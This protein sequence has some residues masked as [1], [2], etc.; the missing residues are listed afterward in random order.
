MHNFFL[1]K[2]DFGALKKKN[3]HKMKN[4]IFPYNTT[5]YARVYFPLLL[6]V[7]HF[8]TLNLTWLLQKDV[9]FSESYTVFHGKSILE[10]KWIC[11]LLTFTFLKKCAS[12]RP[13][14][15]CDLLISAHELQLSSTPWKEVLLMPYCYVTS[16]ITSTKLHINRGNKVNRS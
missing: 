3:E 13:V 2:W 9:S 8:F 16:S 4:G 11:F 7:L 6:C 10:E 5:R 12:Y 15:P 14:E 1:P